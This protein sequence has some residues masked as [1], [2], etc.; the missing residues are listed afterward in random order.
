[1]GELA[2]NSCMTRGTLRC[3]TNPSLA[4]VG[5]TAPYLEEVA[6]VSMVAKSGHPSTTLLLARVRCSWPRCR[7]S[8]YSQRVDA[9]SS[10]Q[11]G[12]S[13]F[14]CGVE[15]LTSTGGNRIAEA[16]LVVLRGLRKATRLNRK[17]GVVIDARSHH[18]RVLVLLFAQDDGQVVA[19]R[20]TSLSCC[21]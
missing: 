2:A 21:L 1:M 18:S 15:Q 12:A 13:D 17:L 14:A 4:I 16:S 11:H 9:S 20:P 7:R 3:W 19:A 10:R 5:H 6:R 8:E